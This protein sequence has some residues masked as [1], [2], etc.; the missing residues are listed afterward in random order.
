VIVSGPLKVHLLCKHT[1]QY[2]LPNKSFAPQKQ[3]IKS[4]I[5]KQFKPG[6]RR[7]Y[8]VDG[9]VILTENDYLTYQRKSLVENHNNCYLSDLYDQDYLLN[10]PR[11][12]MSTEKISSSCTDFFNG[13]WT[14]RLLYSKILGR[15]DFTIAVACAKQK[16]G[17]PRYLYHPELIE[18]AIVSRT[19]RATYD[20]WKNMARG[21][22]PELIQLLQHVRN[23]ISEPILSITCCQRSEN[24]CKEV[25]LEVERGFV[26]IAPDSSK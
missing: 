20:R 8:G 15:H 16:N 23:Q 2:M 25:G 11:R 17:A 19:N 10:P 1:W 7:K 22:I 3:I 24:L 12:S 6:I 21:S 13:I 18:R 9:Q 14:I 5:D 26:I 4:L